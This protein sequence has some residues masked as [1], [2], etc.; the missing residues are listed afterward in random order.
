MK[1]CKNIIHNI[2]INE[3]LSNKYTDYCVYYV[4]KNLRDK[5]NEQIDLLHRY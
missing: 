4:G 5:I 3:I 1:N 2:V